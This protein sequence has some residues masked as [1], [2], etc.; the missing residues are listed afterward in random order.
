MTL[1]L[2]PI[3]ATERARVNAVSRYF[4]AAICAAS[5]GIHAA[6][7]PEHLHEGGPLLGGAFALSAGLLA[8]AA[9][10]V[11]H[12][13]RD[14]WAPRATIVVLVGTAVAYALSRTTGIPPL[15]TTPEAAD[16]LGE[17]TSAF[18]VAG[19]IACFALITRKDAI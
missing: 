12:P 17:V 19:A 5:A 16:R 11:R 4:A 18:E 2:T 10:A 3:V 1:S 15:I 13:R 9:L 8:V 14:S 6:L 7:V